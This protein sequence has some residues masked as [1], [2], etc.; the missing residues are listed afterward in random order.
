M[1]RKRSAPDETLGAL[2][3]LFMQL[4]RLASGADEGIWEEEPVDLDTFVSSKEYLGIESE[5]GGPLV[6][7]PTQRLLIER[8][9]DLTKPADLTY[10]IV[11]VGKGGGKD[12]ITALALCRM[13]YKLLCLRNPQRY[14]GI[15]ATEPIDILN[16]AVASDQANKVFFG[17]FASM[18]RGAG[19]KAF[20]QFGFDPERDILAREIKFPKN[21]T[22]YSGHSEA[23]SQEGKNLFFGIADELDAFKNPVIWDMM[24]SSMRSRFKT[25]GR[26]VAISYIR[27]EDSN[28][29][30]Q[31]LLDQHLQS[32]RP[33]EGWDAA[34]NGEVYINSVENSMVIRAATWQ[35]RHNISREDFAIDY[36]S[37]PDWAACVY[38][39]RRSAGAADNFIKDYERARRSM[40][41]SGRAHPIDQLLVEDYVNSPW[42]ETLRASDRSPLDPYALPFLPHFRGDPRRSYILAGDPGLG[43][44]D[45]GGDSYGVCLAHVEWVRVKGE[46]RPRPVVDMMFRFTGY[47]FPSRQIEFRA[48]YNLIARL[49]DELGF[50]IILYSFDAWNSA[51]IVQWVMERYPG[52]I[53]FGKHV[54][55]IEDYVALRDAIFAE[56]PPTAA[57]LDTVTP[58][59]TNAG[60]DWYYHPVAFKELVNLKE[61]KSR[62]KVDHPKSGPTGKDITD[63][64]AAAVYF[65]TRS[66]P[67]YGAVGDAG[68]AGAGEDGGRGGEK[69]RAK[70][71][72]KQPAYG[73]LSGLL[74]GLP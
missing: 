13:I 18:L 37:R 69:P 66:W 68:D 65:I 41:R 63:P 72:E 31:A 32:A 20:A 26:L 42:S 2:D 57:A 17:K 45:T 59:E 7:Y 52:A 53:V 40:L 58:E 71:E 27:Y 4:D 11:A 64:V 14:L 9:T 67:E 6:L 55:G 35:F 28:G 54:V 62:R 10:F 74:P 21:I 70:E 56:E 47:M 44:V 12:F 1:L 49:N 60:I 38:E 22:A 51:D 19:P 30:L 16:V 29:M 15:V 73:G 23:N 5:D 50:N 25:M 8:V 34:R 46:W 3:S 24:R 36:R 43:A 39:C 48:V 33:L 61:D